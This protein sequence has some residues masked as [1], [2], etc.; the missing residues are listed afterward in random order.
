MTA[1]VTSL[2]KVFSKENIT[3]ANASAFQLLMSPING[4]IL[5]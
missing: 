5:I 1:A 4:T 3:K 2:I